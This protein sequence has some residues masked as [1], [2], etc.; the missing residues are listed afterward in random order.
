M[1]AASQQHPIPQQPMYAAQQQS[2]PFFTPRQPSPAPMFL[3]PMP[4]M[5]TFPMPFYPSMPQMPTF[6][7]QLCTPQYRQ[8][9]YAAQQQPAQL[10]TPPF[11]QPMFAAPPQPVQ[12]CTPELLM[13]QPLMQLCTPDQQMPQPP[14][15]QMPGAPQG[16]GLP[17]MGMTVDAP[18]EKPVTMKIN[19]P[20]LGPVTKSP[21]DALDT[22][23]RS[24]FLNGYDK[25][26]NLFE[27][28]LDSLKI[29]QIVTRCGEQGYRVNMLD[30]MKDPTFK[31]IVAC[32]KT[33]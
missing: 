32:M 27:Q 18:I 1:N 33:K 7:A 19:E 30:I 12:L 25:Q 16:S 15:Q 26:A 3:T 21:E 20:R 17:F 8:P 14:M 4:Q 6:P 31:G 11:Q 28:G 10:C 13:L 29:M 9:M 23:L 5:P 24:I 2:A 22:V